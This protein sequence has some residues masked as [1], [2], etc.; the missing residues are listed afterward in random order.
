M[1]SVF[2]LQSKIATSIPVDHVN[3]HVDATWDVELV[4]MA[5]RILKF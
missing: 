4:G 5:S 2:F 3:M 1:G